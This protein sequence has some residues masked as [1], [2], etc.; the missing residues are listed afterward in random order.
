M[1]TLMVSYDLKLPENSND[2]KLL[3]E[4]IKKYSCVKILKSQWLIKTDSSS[5]KVRDDLKKFLDQ[6]D[7]LFVTP[8]DANDW[9]S[10][11]LPKS[12][13]DWI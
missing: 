2:Y 8:F 1:S 13:V 3:I 5:V 6:N 4:N 10:Y 11:N 7:V 12:A 9:A